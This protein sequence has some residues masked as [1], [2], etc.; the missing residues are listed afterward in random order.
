MYDT[1][2]LLVCLGL[3]RITSYIRYGR[4]L[5]FTGSAY[6]PCFSITVNLFEVDLHLGDTELPFG[7]SI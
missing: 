3:E 2:T 5:K 1:S 6:Y 4:E 7:Y